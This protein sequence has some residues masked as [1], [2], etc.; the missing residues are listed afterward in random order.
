MIKKMSSM[1]LLCFCGTMLIASM[2]C[3]QDDD[4]ENRVAVGT[5]ALPLEEHIAQQETRAQLSSLNIQENGQ[6]A[7]EA[8]ATSQE[9]SDD[10][11][12]PQMLKMEDS[13]RIVQ[14]DIFF[15][16][17]EGAFH[18]VFSVGICGDRVELEDGSIWSVYS[19]DTYK[20]LNWIPSDVIVITPN[21][22]W[23][24][25]YNFRLTNQ[26][27]G[28]SVESNLTLGPIYNAPFTHWIVSI[29]YYNH[30]VYLEDGTIWKM[31]YFDDYIFRKWVIND[32]VI[33]GINDG[34]LSSS[35]PNI[36]INVN[37]LNYA[38]GIVA[39]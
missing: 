29:D 11:H 34:W 7:E 6:P 32:T 28:V 22:S 31:S 27:T 33:I 16:S 20:T 5:R 26:N 15:T 39:Y 30:M 19:G 37:M 18:R 8:I 38:Q 35:R 12:A 1:M 23:F 2:L 25:S 36:L 4:T 24:S 9:G 10:D 13:E 3:G 17:H 21:H 14:H